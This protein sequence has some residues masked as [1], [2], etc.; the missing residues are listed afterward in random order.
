MD[1]KFRPRR[2]LKLPT[3]RATKLP[4]VNWFSALRRLWGAQERVK[5]PTDSDTPKRTPEK[6]AERFGSSTFNTL[7]PEELE[8]LI[9][10]DPPPQK[11]FAR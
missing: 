9:D 3:F 1:R 10:A 11:R 2:D 7:S 4:P 6:E 8:D 5:T